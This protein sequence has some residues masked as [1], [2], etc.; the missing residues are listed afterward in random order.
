MPVLQS[1]PELLRA[2]EFG[3]LIGF[4]SAGAAVTI[5]RVGNGVAGGAGVPP[6]H[7]SIVLPFEPPRPESRLRPTI[8]RVL[9]T[10][11]G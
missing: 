11:P 6:S 5:E 8:R 10:G 2:V 7:L 3:H 4:G 1:L 9:G